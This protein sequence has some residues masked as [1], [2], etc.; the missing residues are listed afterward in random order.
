MS[1]LPIASPPGLAPSLRSSAPRNT[2]IADATRELW[3]IDQAYAAGWKERDANS[4]A[5]LQKARDEELDACCKWLET[6]PYGFSIAA[7][8]ADL[9]GQ[10]RAAR[11]PQSPTLKQLIAAAIE[12]GDERTALRLL[13]E[14]LPND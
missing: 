13:N 14:V 4:E 1:D 6:G 12:D 2:R 9:T 8:A 11:R 3:L 7:T 5:E 10:L